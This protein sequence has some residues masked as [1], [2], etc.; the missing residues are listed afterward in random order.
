MR[1]AV[2]C[3]SRTGSSAFVQLVS[4]VYGI[5]NY[6]EIFACEPSE[7]ENIIH[8]LRS[9]DNYVVKIT[10]TSFLIHKMSMHNF[11]WGLFDRVICL[12]RRVMSQQ[13]A[14]WVLLSSAQSNGFFEQRDVYAYI[15]KAISNRKPLDIDLSSIKSIVDDINFYKIELYPFIRDTIDHTHIYHESFSKPTVGAV[16]RL[17]AAIGIPVTLE[18]LESVRGGTDRISYSSFIRRTKLNSKIKDLTNEYTLRA[19]ELVRSFK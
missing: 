10:S 4:N 14:S 6:S 2:I 13:V 12:E 16:R 1:I 7:C 5:K 11:E 8:K 3:S 9:T 17:S 18:D 15:N 19:Q